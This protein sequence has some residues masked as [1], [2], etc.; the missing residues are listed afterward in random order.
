MEKFVTNDRKYRDKIIMNPREAVYVYL[1]CVLGCP[2]KKL[3][4][5][6][7]TLFF[8]GYQKKL[9]VFTSKKR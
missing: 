7:S 5:F 8:G 6:C 9:R 2:I 3:N 4:F 1:G